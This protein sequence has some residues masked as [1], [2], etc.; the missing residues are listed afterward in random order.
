MLYGWV[1]HDIDVVVMVGHQYQSHVSLQQVLKGSDGF[2]P[3]GFDQDS[4]PVA[5]ECVEEKSSEDT[6]QQKTNV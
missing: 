6:P 3:D 2:L 5:E 1:S 4:Q